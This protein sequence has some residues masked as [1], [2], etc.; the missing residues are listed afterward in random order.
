[1]HPRPKATMHTIGIQT[2]LSSSFYHILHTHFILFRFGGMQIK[3]C[4]NENWEKKK[5]LFGYINGMLMEKA[6]FNLFNEWIHARKQRITKNITLNWIYHV[7][8]TWIVCCKFN[9]DEIISRLFFFF[10]ACIFLLLFL[11]VAV[12]VTCVA[13]DAH[14]TTLR[15]AQLYP[16]NM[17][18]WITKEHMKPS[19]MT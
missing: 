10:V 16:I 4:F 11:L 18:D 17:S 8:L 12:T 7:L 14:C 2:K 6:T 15:F 3:K 9:F 19:F 5:I 13:P 1:M